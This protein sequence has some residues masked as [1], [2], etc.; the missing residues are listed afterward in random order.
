MAQVAWTGK[1]L[2]R[3][4]V[5]KRHGSRRPTALRRVTASYSAGRCALNSVAD[6]HCEARLSELVFLPSP[7]SLCGIMSPIVAWIPRMIQAAAE[8]YTAAPYGEI[9]KP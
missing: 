5:G 9:P 8:L 1:T 6:N 7:Y 3:K 4:G 2:A